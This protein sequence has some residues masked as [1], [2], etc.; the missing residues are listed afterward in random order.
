LLLGMGCL[1][2]ADSFSKFDKEIIL[3]MAHLY[4]DDFQNERKLEELRCQLDNY[5]K[6]FHDDSRFSDIKGIGDLCRKLV[7][8][9]T[10][11]LSSCVSRPWSEYILQ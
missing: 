6:N 7:E 5:V 10:Y 8:K 4:L 9:K 3:A 1:V 2:P 11:Y